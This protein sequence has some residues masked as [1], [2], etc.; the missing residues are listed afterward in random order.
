MNIRSFKAELESALMITKWSPTDNQL[1]EI[2]KKL[3]NFKGE[4]TKSNVEKVVLDVLGSYEARMLEGV[5]NSDLTT[6][7][8]LATKVDSGK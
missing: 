5:D 3:K 2:A 6:L 7:L 8:M 1:L 4:P